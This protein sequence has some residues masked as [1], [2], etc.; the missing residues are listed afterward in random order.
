MRRERK[1]KRKKIIIF[2][3]IIIV[4]IVAVT[5][6]FIIRNK[7]KSEDTEMKK[8]TTLAEAEDL[9][10]AGI[11][12]TDDAYKGMEFY[13]DGENIV[14]QGENGSRTI[15]TENVD[16]DREMKEISEEDKEKYI[17]SETNIQEDKGQTIITGKITNKAEE[18]KKIIIS[19]KF[20]SEDER[21]K[22]A[23]NCNVTVN[24]GETTDFTMKIQDTVSQYR[25]DIFVEY[26]N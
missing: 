18:T 5:I 14:I 15:S 20:Y 12:T 22:G 11:D 6:T 19:A 23:T 1:N 3:L 2:L 26:T 4:I 24:S 16:K 13:Q 17:I 8:L 7:M 25:S 10:K 21:I 9:E